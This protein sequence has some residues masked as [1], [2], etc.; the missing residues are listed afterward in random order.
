MPYPHEASKVKIGLPAFCRSHRSQSV[1][2]NI[3]FE[4]DHFRHDMFFII[5]I[6]SL[7]IARHTDYA[8]R[9]VAHLA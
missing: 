5:I 2:W 6:H 1:G 9:V 7:Q 8:A 3:F 4:C